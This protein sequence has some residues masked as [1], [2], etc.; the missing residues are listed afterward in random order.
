MMACG[1]GALVAGMLGGAKPSA[2]AQTNATA[3]TGGL[4]TQSTLLGDLGGLRP[5]LGKYGISFGLSETSEVLG[6]VTGGVHRGAD[7]DGLTQMTLTVDTEKAFGLS[8]GTFYGSALQL[9]GRSISSDNL[10]ELHPVSS[11]EGA[12]TT[13]LWE[14]WYDQQLFGGRADV[15]LG[16]QSLDQ[17]FTL[18]QYAGVFVNAT[19]GWPV[20]PTNDLYASG[21][22]YPLSSLG[23]RLRVH[24]TPALTML[25]GVFD[26]NPPG[27]PFNDDSQLRG[28]EAA[29]TQFNLNTG[30]LWIGEVQ[31]TLNPSPAK[32]CKSVTCGL[33]GTYKF[34][35]YYDSGGF[36]DQRFGTDGLL[37]ADPASNGVPR[38]DRGNYGVYAVANQMLWRAGPDSSRSVG[39]FLRA[40]A[41]PG[42]RNL[43]DFSLDAGVTVQAPFAGRDKDT[44]GIAFSYARIS[45]SAVGLDADT[46]FFTG[47]PYPLRSAESLVEVTYQ[48]QLA[49]WWVLQPDF[50][51]VFNPGGGIPGP[52]QGTKR[53]GDEAIIGLRTVITFQ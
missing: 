30:A 49:P 7:Y 44:F 9:H 19:M 20:L 36:L 35:A 34:G 28:G 24:V 1:A 47:T 45:G 25:A 48:A 43:I 29:G 4:W 18:A 42:D 6:N 23:V 3:A 8:G 15:K 38:T 33:P 53:I 16:Q 17:E 26:D 22:V 11:I 31:Y 50:Q 46:A 21:P 52:A 14:L 2:S 13:R 5:L 27:G 12:G 51:Y 40:V 41:A 10:R 37:L 39:A 32:S